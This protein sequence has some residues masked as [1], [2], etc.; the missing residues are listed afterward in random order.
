MPLAA[1]VDANAAGAALDRTGHCLATA[2]YFESRASRSKVSWRS[3]SGYQPRAVGPLSGE[4]CGVVKQRRNSVSF[5]AAAFRASTPAVTPGAGAGNRPHR[6][7]EPDLVAVGR[8]AVVSRRLCRTE[9]GTA[10]GKG[11]KDR[12]AHLLSKLIHRPGAA[13]RRFGVNHV[14]GGFAPR[15]KWLTILLGTKEI[16][17]HGEA[18]AVLKILIVEDDA[19]LATTL[20]YLVEDNPRY[21]VVA[22]ADDLDSAVRGRAISA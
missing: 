13:K 8:C 16:P 6:G 21:R 17:G 3:P 10:P 18:L 5:A 15:P 20:K 2:V 19:Q 12:R 22:T 1:L 9:L 14:Q 4:W 11:G 7:A